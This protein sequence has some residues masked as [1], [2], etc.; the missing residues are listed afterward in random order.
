MDFF[1]TYYCTSENRTWTFTQGLV[2]PWSLVHFPRQRA[3]VVEGIEAGVICTNGRFPPILDADGGTTRESCYSYTIVASV[4]VPLV[5]EE[6][7]AEGEIDAVTSHDER[8]LPPASTSE[9][10]LVTTTTTA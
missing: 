7:T 9:P 6:S 10:V 4:Q 2:R 1:C 8:E 5:A 3:V